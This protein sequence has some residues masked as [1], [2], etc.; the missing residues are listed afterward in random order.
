MEVIK[1]YL[2]KISPGTRRN[3]IVFLGAAGLLLIFLS[4]WIRPETEVR[5]IAEP[6]PESESSADYRKMLETELSE[7][8]SAIDGAGDVKIMITMDSTAEDI[9]AVDKTESESRELS[10]GDDGETRRSAENEYVIVKGKDGSEQ[11]VLKKQRM[12]E[13]RGVLVVCSGGGSSVTREKIT[14]AVSGALGIPR[15]K[16]VVTN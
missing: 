8:V 5:E 3:A 1:K 2:S 15:S 7:I 13:I 4:T 14:Q 9:Y 16:V 10:S 11:A 12:P 6:P